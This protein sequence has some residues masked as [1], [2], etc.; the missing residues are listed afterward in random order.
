[1]KL[2]VAILL[3]ALLAFFGGLYLPWWS[4]ALAAFVSILLVPHS[5]GRAFL[6]GFA[7]VFLLWGLL[8]WWIDVRNQHILS[9]RMAEIFPLGGSPAAIILVTAFVG[10]L[11]AGFAAMSAGYLRGVSLKNL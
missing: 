7:G 6:A 3:T 5:G 10:A 1:M 11:V 2:L 9:K 8:S 4:I